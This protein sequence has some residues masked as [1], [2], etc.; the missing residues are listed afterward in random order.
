MYQYKNPRLNQ[1]DQ[2]LKQI[3]EFEDY[4]TKISKNDSSINKF[5]T[6]RPAAYLRML[7]DNFY[8]YYALAID[9]FQGERLSK[10]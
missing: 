10:L 9:S 1:R 7:E 4:Y 6:L 5:K 8:N 2:I 3:K